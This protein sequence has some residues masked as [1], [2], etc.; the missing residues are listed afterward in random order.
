MPDGDY[1]FLATPEGREIYFHRNSVLTTNLTD[2]RWGRKWPSPRR[3]GTE[4]PRPAP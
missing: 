4:G 2:W 1:G 3:K